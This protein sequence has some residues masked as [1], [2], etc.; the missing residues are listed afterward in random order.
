VPL[1]PRQLLDR[2]TADLS[3]ALGPGLLGLSVHGSWVVGD[4]HLGRSDLDLVAVLADDPTEATLATLTR[5]H[6]ELANDHPEWYEHVEVDYV[7][8][9]A[10][11][12]VLEGKGGRLLVRISPGEPIHLTPATSHYLLNWYTAERHGQVLLGVAPRQILPEIS[13]DEVRRTVL[14]H[15]RQWPGWVEE[16]RSP[17]TQAYAVLT[18][19]RAAAA[20][21]S[22]QQISKRA[23]AAYGTKHLPQWSPLIEWACDWWYGGGQDDEP[24]RFNEVARFVREVTPTILAERA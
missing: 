8:P 2:L 9:Y 11:R 17:G 19:C 21:D 7:S 24:E 4:F 18:V 5:L 22:G 3:A 13:S 1:S 15:L 6:A 12:D 23:A 14:D 16:M 10:V 20:L